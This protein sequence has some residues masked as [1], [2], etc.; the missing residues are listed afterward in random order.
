MNRPGLAIVAVTLLAGC[1]HGPDRVAFIEAFQT[2]QVMLNDDVPARH[3]AVHVETDEAAERD[4]LT[5]T[6]MRVELVL[7]ADDADPWEDVSVDAWLTGDDVT[8]DHLVFQGPGVDDTTLIENYQEECELGS[9]CGWDHDF[10]AER[11]TGASEVA[12]EVSFRAI[13]TLGPEAEAPV[14]AQFSL[15]AIE[16][17]PEQ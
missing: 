12:A 4:G 15:L 11:S 9:P 1:Q 10:V 17:D 5:W 14:G 2:E 6:T 8:E 16:V 7:V 13:V 3:W